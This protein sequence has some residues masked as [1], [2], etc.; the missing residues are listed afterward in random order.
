MEGTAIGWAAETMTPAA[1]SLLDDLIREMDEA[2]QRGDRARYV[3]ANRAFQ[4]AIYR[5]S[6]SDALM[7][8]I[9]SLWLQIGPFFNLLGA[10]DAW[11]ASNEHH[12]VMRSAIAARDPAGARLALRRDI[13]D[14]AMMLRKVPRRPAPQRRRPVGPRRAVERVRAEARQYPG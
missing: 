11:G 6:G 1:L 13:D 12:R 4:F 8:I 2:K 10:S 9:A 7:A 14:A 5:A 3:P